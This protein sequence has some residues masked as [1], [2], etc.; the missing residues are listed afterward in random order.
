MSSSS[1]FSGFF[2]LKDVKILGIIARDVV[3]LFQQLS[4]D[5][6]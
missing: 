2:E 3:T 6:L 5:L 1:A 4:V